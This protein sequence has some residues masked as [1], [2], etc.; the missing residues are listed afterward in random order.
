MISEVHTWRLVQAVQMSAPNSVQAADMVADGPR[1]KVAALQ[2]AAREHQPPHRACCLAGPATSRLGAF[3]TP[4]SSA[5]QQAVGLVIAGIQK[6]LHKTRGRYPNGGMEIDKRQ[7][8]NLN[9]R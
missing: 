5:A 8:L 4:A 9:G 6:N 7:R 1:H 2:P 3:W